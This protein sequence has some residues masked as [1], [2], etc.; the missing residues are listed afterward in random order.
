MKVILKR[1]LHRQGWG[2]VHRLKTVWANSPAVLYIS[3]YAIALILIRGL[4][5]TL[6]NHCHS[7]A[8]STNANENST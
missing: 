3:H 8:L 6:E 4:T 7:V 1:F 5:N 2:E